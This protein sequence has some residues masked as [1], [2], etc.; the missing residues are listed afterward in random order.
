MKGLLIIAKYI[1]AVAVIAGAALWFNAKFETAVDTSSAVI[2]SLEV[3]KEEILYINA[4]QAMMSEQIQGVQDTLDDFEAEHK[5]QSA[6]IKSLVWG[7]KN[8]ER[9]TPED[10][11]EIMNEMLNKK[12]VPVYSGSVEFI[13]ID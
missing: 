7:M 9:F 12:A 6:Q 5:K 2:D 8:I 10:F 4:E 13:P 11:E 3:I 1:S